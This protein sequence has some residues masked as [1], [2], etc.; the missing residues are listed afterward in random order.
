[1]WDRKTANKLVES[2]KQADDSLAKELAEYLEM[3]LESVEFYKKEMVKAF[4]SIEQLS[5]EVNEK[6][7]KRGEDGQV[8]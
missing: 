6:N 1:M 5:Q 2:G 4:K 8:E 7:Y 3:A